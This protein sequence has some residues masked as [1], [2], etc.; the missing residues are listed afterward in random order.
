MYGNQVIQNLKIH[1]NEKTRSKILSEYK[2]TK[3]LNLKIYKDIVWK[4]KLFSCFLSDLI[5]RNLNLIK[6]VQII[7]LINYGIRK[8]KNF[9]LTFS[10]YLFCLRVGTLNVLSVILNY[11]LTDSTFKEFVCIFNASYEWEY[12]SSFKSALICLKKSIISDKKFKLL[13][14]EYLRISIFFLKKISQKL[15]SIQYKQLNIL[16]NQL[17]LHVICTIKHLHQSKKYL[18]FFVH[19]LTKEIWRFANLILSVKFIEKLIKIKYIGNRFLII[20]SFQYVIIQLSV[21]ILSAIQFL[22]EIYSVITCIKF[23]HLCLYKFI[24]KKNHIFIME[25]KKAKIF[26]FYLKNRIEFSIIRLILIDIVL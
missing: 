20:N 21:K 11:K 6:K 22:N 13:H 18:V 25:Y 14:K 15:Y 7:S 16:I 10:F 5:V 3:Y 26:R 19:V 23:K 2:L 9:K 8:L 12:C 24:L 17:L 1:L 4:K